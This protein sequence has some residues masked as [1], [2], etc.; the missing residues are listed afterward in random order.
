[1]LYTATWRK[2]AFRTFHSQINCCV[3]SLEDTGFMLAASKTVFMPITT[4]GKR[5]LPH[6]AVNI[7]GTPLIP[8]SSVKYVPKKQTPGRTG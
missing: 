4:K 5:V 8:S 3:H 7:N 1:M 6:L 2:Y